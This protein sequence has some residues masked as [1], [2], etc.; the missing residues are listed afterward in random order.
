[1]SRIIKTIE[2]EGV[3]TVALFD[4]GALYTYVRS[5]LAQDAPRI[6]MPSPPIV[7]YRR[8]NPGNPRNLPYQRENRRIRFRHRRRPHR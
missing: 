8:T 1:M 6:K 2:I 4:T 5:S 3:P 7:R